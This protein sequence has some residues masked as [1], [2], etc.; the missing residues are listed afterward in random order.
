[1]SRMPTNQK[2]GFGSILIVVTTMIGV[3][4]IAVAQ[5]GSFYVGAFVGAEHISFEHAK[6][7]DNTNV[8]TN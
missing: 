7:V 3:S 8:P 4:E 6:T 2:T 1:M 5:N